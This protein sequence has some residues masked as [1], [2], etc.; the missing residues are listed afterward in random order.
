M[1]GDEPSGNRTLRVYVIL[2][3]VRN[4]YSFEQ[5][6]DM[7]YVFRELLCCYVVTRPQTRKLKAGKPVRRS[8]VRP[9][10]VEWFTGLGG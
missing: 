2:N 9:G 1:R 10:K 5:R 7:S 6:N 8:C 4:H 3:L